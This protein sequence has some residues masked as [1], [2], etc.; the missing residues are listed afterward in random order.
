MQL[1]TPKILC[2]T[3]LPRLS[4]ELSSISSMR[5]EALCSDATISFISESTS[6]EFLSDV[7]SV[8]EDGGTWSHS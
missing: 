2:A 1:A 6:I 3:G 5:R 8:V 7:A 4:F